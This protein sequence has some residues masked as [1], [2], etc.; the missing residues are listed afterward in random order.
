MVK[1]LLE[2]LTTCEVDRFFENCESL[3]RT[4]DVKEEL[5]N[6]VNHTTCLMDNYVHEKFIGLS[7][8][9]REDLMTLYS[10]TQAI[11]LFEGSIDYMDC[12]K[13]NFQIRFHFS[14]L[15]NKDYQFCANIHVNNSSYEK[16]FLQVLS[17]KKKGLLPWK[18]KKTIE[19]RVVEN[20]SVDKLFDGELNEYLT[21]FKMKYRSNLNDIINQDLL[22]RN[23]SRWRKE[24][25]DQLIEVL[26]TLPEILINRINI[27]NSQLAEALK[28]SQIELSKKDD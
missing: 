26:C 6:H 7:E 25:Y 1:S 11:N 24:Y 13:D 10:T 8:R 3:I 15:K 28:Q 18:K 21:H 4:F 20:K 2:E 19:I 27:Y 22:K 14:K 23:P 9:I 5:E 16:T 12:P 17:S